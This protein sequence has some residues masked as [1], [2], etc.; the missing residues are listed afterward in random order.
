MQGRSQSGTGARPKQWPSR[1]GCEKCTAQLA[2]CAAAAGVYE[3]ER[4][5]TPDGFE[6]TWQASSQ[7]LG[8]HSGALAEGAGPQHLQATAS[9]RCR[10]CLAFW[11]AYG[12]SLLSSLQWQTRDA[13]CAKG[14][15]V[16]MVGHED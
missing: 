5:V 15:S 11:R 13:A 9:L 1:P 2:L 7:I 8:H 12:H 10:P 6:M 16:G 14:L 4:K 3:T